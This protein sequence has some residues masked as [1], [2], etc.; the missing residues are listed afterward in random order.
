MRQVA[1]RARAQQRQI[2]VGIDAE[3]ARFH[4]PAF[5]IHQPHRPGA[6]NNMRIGQHKPVRRDR[7]AG[8][9]TGRL[10]GP[11][12]GFHAQ[13]SGSHGVDD[14]GHRVRVSIQNF[15][16]GRKRRRGVVRAFRCGRRREIEHDRYP[17]QECRR[18]SM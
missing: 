12:I 17:G 8:A 15:G 9:G 18:G 10:A 11:A 2:G 1:R 3:H 16:I 4:E 7:H 5:G 14:G 6:F 13:H